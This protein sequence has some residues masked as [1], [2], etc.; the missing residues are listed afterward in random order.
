MGIETMGPPP[1][2][3]EMLR[4]TLGLKVF[5]ETGTL[6]GLTTKWAADRFERAITIEASKHYF[7]MAQEDFK[8]YTNINA[9]FGDT[10]QELAKMVGGLPPTLFFLDA[11]WSGGET[12]GQDSECPLLTEL[13]LI[14]PWFRKHAIMIDDARLFLQPPAYPHRLEEWPSIDDIVRAT[15][16]GAYVAYYRDVLV[17]VPSVHRVKIASAIQQLKP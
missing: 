2:L 4:D 5:V 11:H 12:A 9:I 14:M 1:E 10:S 17:L 6:T 13:G 8:R 3:A 15:N 7:D 16:G